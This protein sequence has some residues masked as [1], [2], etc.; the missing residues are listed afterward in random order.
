MLVPLPNPSTRVLRGNCERKIVGD[1]MEFVMGV[2]G[3]FHG[4]ACQYSLCMWK[5]PTSCV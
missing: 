5:P 2:I 3:R 1:F 4:I